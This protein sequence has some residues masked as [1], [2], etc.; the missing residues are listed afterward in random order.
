M[1]FYIVVLEQDTV[2]YASLETLSTL[3]SQPQRGPKRTYFIFDSHYLK[4]VHIDDF[5]GRKHVQFAYLRL[6]IY[7]YSKW[8]EQQYL[9]NELS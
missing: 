7:L 2:S 1:W 3:A 4:L 8:T 6:T 9:F 5:D